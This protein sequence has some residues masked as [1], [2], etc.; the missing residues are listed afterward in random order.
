MDGFAML[1][2][3]LTA[4]K[5]GNRTPMGFEKMASLLFRQVQMGH[6][7]AKFHKMLVVWTVFYIEFFLTRLLAQDAE[8]IVDK[9]FVAQDFVVERFQMKL[10][11]PHLCKCK[12]Y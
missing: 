11:S 5:V 1:T 9:H 10:G 8:K 6:W 3:N 4:K 2:H 12:L 7:H